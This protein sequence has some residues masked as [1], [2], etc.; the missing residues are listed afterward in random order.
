MA[1]LSRKLALLLVQ[2]LSTMQQYLTSLLFILLAFSTLQA[3]NQ[4]EGSEQLKGKWRGSITQPS[5]NGIANQY[6]FEIEITSI[7][8]ERFV[9]GFTTISLLKR[10][11]IYGKIAFTGFF[12]NNTLSFNEVQIVDANNPVGYW[13]LKQGYASIAYQDEKVFLVGEW[14]SAM[15]Q[16]KNGQLSVEKVKE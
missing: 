14:N 2:K 1:F 5:P 16:G 9:E 15:M 4:Y 3:Q 11:E 12:S 13:F 7:K 8:K 10:P 6:N